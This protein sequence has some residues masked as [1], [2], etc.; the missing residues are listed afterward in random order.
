MSGT[1]HSALY[2]GR[3]HHRRHRPATH[4]FDLPLRMVYLDLDELEQVFAGRWLWSTR[5]PNLEWFRRRDYLDP[6]TPDLARAVRDRA[7]AETGRRVNGAVRVLTQLRSWGYCFNPVTFYYCHGE[8]GALEAIVTE[9]TNTPWG[10]RFTYVLDARTGERRGEWTGFRFAK[11]FH[12]SPF[13]PMALDYDWR[14]QTPGARLG[15]HMNVLR[16]GVHMFDATLTLERRE[17]TGT[18]LAHAV[19]RYPAMGLQVSARIYWEAWRL[20]RKRV[21]FYPHPAKAGAS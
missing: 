17:I 7:A 10:E 2:V 3:L 12:V 14:F 20:W 8:A 19:W 5:Y 1:L 11:R 4:A 18:S 6:E 21:P 9:I 13:M 15:V 16:Q